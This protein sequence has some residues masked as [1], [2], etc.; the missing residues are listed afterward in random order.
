MRKNIITILF[1]L[2]LTLVFNYRLVGSLL[3]NRNPSNIAA[4]DNVIVEFVTEISYQNLKELKNPFTPTNRF[5]YP[6]EINY[7]LSDA[8]TSD[9]LFF[10]LLRPFLDS[11]QSLVLILLI[12]IFLSLFVMHILLRSFKINYYISFISSLIYGFTPYISQRIQGH[13]TY[14]SIY[15]FPLTLLIIFKFLKAKEFKKK[16]ILSVIFGLVPMKVSASL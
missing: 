8:S 15:L 7:Y 4:N 10:L 16:F 3:L 9:L 11:Y 1:F 5:L 14:T 2:I 12:N 6:F 13:D